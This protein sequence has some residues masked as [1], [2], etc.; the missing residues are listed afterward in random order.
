MPIDA[1]SD[2]LAPRGSYAMVVPQTF[3]ELHLDKDMV[4]NVVAY[5][6][7]NKLTGEVSDPICA[8]QVSYMFPLRL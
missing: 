8:E 2:P 5:Y 1:A 7:F 4:G 3:V 6:L